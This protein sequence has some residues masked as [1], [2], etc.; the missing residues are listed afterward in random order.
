MPLA[1]LLNRPCTVVHRSP[2]NTEEDAYGNFIP[3]ETATE[4]VCELQQHPGSDSESEDQVSANRWAL[5]LPAETES[6]SADTVTIDGE[7]YEVLAEPWNARNP[8]SQTVSHIEV[9]V[10]R[11]AAMGDA[12]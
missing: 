9:S 12:S 3:V 11:T 4:T 1:K 2:S 8:R 10:C 7:D 5:F 6:G